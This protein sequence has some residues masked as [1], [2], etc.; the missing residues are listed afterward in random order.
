MVDP[1]KNCILYVDDEQNNLVTFLATFRRHYNV[2]TATSGRE[3]MEVLRTQPIE[4]IITDQRMPEMTG[5]QF[6]E[7][8]IPDF[9]DVIRMILTG[10]SDVEAIIKAINSGRV[11][12]YI[13]KPWDENELKL[14]IDTGLAI[15]K[16]E[17]KNKDLIHQLNEELMRQQQIMN[18][19]QKYVPDAVLKEMLD[20]AQ[21][22][23]ILGENR[24]VAVLFIDIR[25]FTPL[26]SRLEA[27]LIVSLLNDFF[28]M[29]TNCVKRH[30][31]SINKFLGDGVLAIF[32]APVSY[33]DN[34]HNA[35]YCSL[36]ILATLKEF[37][38][39]WKDKIDQSIEIGIGINTGEV[40][41]GNMGS[42]ERIEY[43]V[44][45]D[46]VNVASRIQELTKLSPNSIIISESTFNATKDVVIV[47]EMEAQQIRG[48]EEKMK[49]YK[50]IGR[51]S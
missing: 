4:L 9:P 12:R 26:A 5:V 39:K 36:D 33:I 37:S 27:R 25:N 17:M 1:K 44:I 19:F 31:G 45:G 7:A 48:K 32:G 21:S 47:E 14:C 24:V 3:G 22:S 49:L 30:K 41:V 42:D 51:K 46:T 29:I 15:Y 34:P 11:F 43:S 35:V 20:N 13:T 23:I 28:T 40:V 6:L 50:L 38:E 2:F 18:L 16:L 10:F 8:V